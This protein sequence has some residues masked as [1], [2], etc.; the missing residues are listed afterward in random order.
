M[1]KLFYL[2]CHEMQESWNEFSDILWEPKSDSAE[3]SPQQL[4]TREKIETELTEL[5]DTFDKHFDKNQVYIYLHLI[6]WIVSIWRFTN[7]AVLWTY[8][9]IVFYSPILV[10]FWK[11][12]YWIS[13]KNLYYLKHYRH[14]ARSLLKSVKDPMEHDNRP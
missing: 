10:Y 14:E 3:F 2:F 8:L 11:A 4:A 13:K 5:F 7:I 9:F 12:L 1:V 6:S